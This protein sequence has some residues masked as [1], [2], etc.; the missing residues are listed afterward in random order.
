MF[1]VV[2]AHSE[3]IDT[4]DVIEDLLDQVREDLG[5]DQP[6]AGLLFA[7]VDHDWD[8]IG[9]RGCNHDCGPGRLVDFGGTGGI[10]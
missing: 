4:E 1:K 2:I 6:K 9:N 8:P 10:F 5:D 7:C 3:D